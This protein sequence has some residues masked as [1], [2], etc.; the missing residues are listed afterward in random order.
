MLKSNAIDFTDKKACEQCGSFRKIGTRSTRI[1]TIR[2][3]QSKF[4][5][6]VT[7]KDCLENLA[8][9]SEGKRYRNKQ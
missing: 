4:Q 5:E 2:K 9:T 3:R 6:H 1:L 8:L 7:R